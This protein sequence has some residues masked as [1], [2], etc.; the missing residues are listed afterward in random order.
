MKEILTGNRKLIIDLRS[1]IS[2]HGSRENWMEKSDLRL[3]R[4]ETIFMKP[5]VNTPRNVNKYYKREEP[6]CSR[7]RD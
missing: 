5:D 1:T 7:D 4:N 6:Y 2:F 3:V